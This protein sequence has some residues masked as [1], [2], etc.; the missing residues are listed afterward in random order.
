MALDEK[1]DA[2]LVSSADRLANML[3]ERRW[4][5]S[6]LWPFIQTSY[7]QYDSSAITCRCVC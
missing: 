5:C 7:S 1:I 6:S 3:E 2:L 4:P